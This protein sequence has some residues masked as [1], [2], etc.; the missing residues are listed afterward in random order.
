M[1]HVVTLFELIRQSV[2]EA[3]SN[4]VIFDIDRSL[5]YETALLHYGTALLHYRTALQLV[6]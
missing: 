4:A 1:G 3:S 5:H 2:R 6:F